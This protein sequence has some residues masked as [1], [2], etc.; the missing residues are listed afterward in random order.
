MSSRKPPSGPLA[1][2]TGFVVIPATAIAS[3]TAETTVSAIAN[4]QVPP[5][6]TA[7]ANMNGKVMSTNDVVSWSPR[8]VP[9][10]TTSGVPVQLVYARVLSVQAATIGTA[11]GIIQLGFHA[12]VAGAAATVQANTI[13]IDVSLRSSDL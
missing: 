13:D 3:S 9:L 4:I 5:S 7:T 2:L 12:G 11:I 1:S 10:S 8:V 6:G